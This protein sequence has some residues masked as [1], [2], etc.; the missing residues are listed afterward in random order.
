MS[1]K[2]DEELLANPEFISCLR[3]VWDLVRPELLDG[4]QVLAIDNLIKR[5][6]ATHPV[7]GVTEKRNSDLHPPDAGI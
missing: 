3:H 5:L 4:P 6:E 1:G 2:H 7:L